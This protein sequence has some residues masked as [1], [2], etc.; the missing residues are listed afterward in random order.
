MQ[1]SIFGVVIQYWFC[2]HTGN[3]IE[4]R[5]GFETRTPRFLRWNQHTLCKKLR[6]DFC[7]KARK[8]IDMTW[9]EHQ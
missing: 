2:E 4:K 5:Q 1:N 9:F 8:G 3:Y 7:E 6:N